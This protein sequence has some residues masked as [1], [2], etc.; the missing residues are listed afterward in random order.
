[1]A[2]KKDQICSAFTADLENAEAENRST[3][4]NITIEGISYYKNNLREKIQV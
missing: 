2:L 4:N 3:V 1:M